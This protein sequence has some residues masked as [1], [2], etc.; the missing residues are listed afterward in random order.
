MRELGGE[1]S[2]TLTVKGKEV[3]VAGAGA[4]ISRAAR[5]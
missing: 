4:E 5:K 3:I 2:A 1:G